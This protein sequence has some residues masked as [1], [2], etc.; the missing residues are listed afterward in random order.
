MVVAI[1]GDGILSCFHLE[2]GA[3]IGPA[4]TEYRALDCCLF[5]KVPVL[6]AER[7]NGGSLV[8]LSDFSANGALHGLEGSVASLALSSSLSD[9]SFRF[10][11]LRLF[12]ASE[13]I[14]EDRDKL[15]LARRC[16]E[17]A[18]FLSSHSSPLTLLFRLVVLRLSGSSTDDESLG[19]MQDAAGIRRLLEEDLGLSQSSLSSSSQLTALWCEYLG[20]MQLRLGLKRQAV[21]TFLQCT[22]PENSLYNGLMATIVSSTV[23]EDRAAGTRDMLAPT[24]TVVAGTLVHTHNM[25]DRGVDLLVAVDRVLDACTLLQTFD[26]WTE[27]ALLAKSLVVRGDLSPA[28]LQ[29]VFRRWA[30]DCARV[31]RSFAAAVLVSVDEWEAAIKVLSSSDDGSLLDWAAALVMLCPQRETGDGGVLAFPSLAELR[32]HVMSRYAPLLHQTGLL[33]HAQFMWSQAGSEVAR[34]LAEKLWL[35][36]P[37]L[38]PGPGTGAAGSATE[39]HSGQQQEQA[40]R[41]STMAAAA[42]A[43][44]M[45]WGSVLP[46]LLQQQQQQPMSHAHS[47]VHGPIDRMYRHLL[48]HWAEH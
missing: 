47:V 27:S 4:V 46:E 33:S 42:S 30:M 48:M 36:G 32:E 23:S 24:A 38:S 7:I 6:V 25:L 41:H 10:R 18:S 2:Q 13:F 9:A 37:S 34:M 12:P 20:R 11:A 14:P 1:H 45:E 16:V 15:A 26:R 43:S 31:S 40:H 8:L 28:D 35:Q 44:G 19:L 29:T 39:S 17:T 22:S 21:T 3:R 5:G